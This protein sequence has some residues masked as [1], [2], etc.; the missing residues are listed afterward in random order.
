MERS[1]GAT[2]SVGE[3][4][5]AVETGDGRLVCSF[6]GTD[7]I[8]GLSPA[9]FASTSI[10]LRLTILVGAVTPLVHGRD[11]ARGVAMG[12]ALLLTARRVL[13]SAPT[14]I[15]AENYGS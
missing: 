9:V 11:L 4:A 7:S 5:R 13:M 14:R 15:S 1:L 2:A 6:L 3:L 10:D 12:E 8:F